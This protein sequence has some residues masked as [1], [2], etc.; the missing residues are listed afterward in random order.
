MTRSTGL[1]LILLAA[2]GACNREK[3]AA[4][5]HQGQPVG[6]ANAEH[7]PQDQ[8]TYLPEQKIDSIRIEGSTEPLTLKV[9]QPP[10]SIPFV[11]Y[12]P[13]DMLFEPGAADEGEG[14]YFYTNFGRRR[15]ENAYLLMFIYPD[16]T[17]QEDAI[18][19]VK[20]WVAS[21]ADVPASQIEQFRFEKDG[22]R[23]IAGI[24][25]RMHG[26]R[27]YHVAEQY[28]EEYAEGFSPRA[29]RILDEW[30]WLR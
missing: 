12:V 22:T 27:Y 24:D 10:S 7:Q 13:S 29:Q 16:G 5:R 21:R 26:N 14:F 19:R 17:K 6:A 15:N 18:R 3:S 23:Y 9:I 25:L 30:K 2:L 20:A 28:P 11:T 4:D 8:L 1:F